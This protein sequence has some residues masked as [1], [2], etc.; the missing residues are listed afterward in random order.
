MTLVCMLANTIDNDGVMNTQ[1]KLTSN[2]AVFSFQTK[3][4]LIFL[5][6]ILFANTSGVNPALP[7][8]EI[9]IAEVHH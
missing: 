6:L 1:T 3:A 4:D 8:M 2:R 5:C 9:N 7:L